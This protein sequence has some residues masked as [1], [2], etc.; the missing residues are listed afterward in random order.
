[1]ITEMANGILKLFS[2]MVFIIV[3][4]TIMFDRTALSYLNIKLFL[5]NKQPRWMYNTYTSYL[6]MIEYKYQR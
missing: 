2:I 5:F 4:P 1:M 3:W 6:A